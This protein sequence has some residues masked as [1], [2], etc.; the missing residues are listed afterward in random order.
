MCK[1]W[2]THDFAHVYQSLDNP[3]QALYVHQWTEGLAVYTSGHLSE[4]IVNR[5]PVR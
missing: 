4:R 2:F 3:T 1:L 5:C